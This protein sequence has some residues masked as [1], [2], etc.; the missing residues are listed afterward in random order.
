MNRKEK[1]FNTNRGKKSEEEKEFYLIP[2]TRNIRIADI[3]GYAYVFLKRVSPR[4]GKLS[5][6]HAS[7]IPLKNHLKQLQ[8]KL[9][10]K[11]FP[12]RPT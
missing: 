6:P 5:K 4:V 12:R 11:Y 7:P 3:K 8:Q 2:T 10:L 1:K 9:M